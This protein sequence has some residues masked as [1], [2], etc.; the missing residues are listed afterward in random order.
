[1]TPMT[2]NMPVTIWPGTVVNHQSRLLENADPNTSRMVSAFKETH[3]GKN[4][5]TPDRDG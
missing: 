2:P 5:S 4:D 1:M 3:D